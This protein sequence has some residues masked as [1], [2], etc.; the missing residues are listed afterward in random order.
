MEV[1]AAAGPQV[2]APETL[3]EVLKEISR[4]KALL[5]T[6]AKRSALE[7]SCSQQLEGLLQKEAPLLQAARAE[8]PP[9]CGVT[10]LPHEKNSFDLWAERFADRWLG[11]GCTHDPVPGDPA[12][13]GMKK[14]AS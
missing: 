3:E 14:K 11:G 5:R 1:P 12:H 7:L 10:L 6:A 13:R 4:V 8:R 9:Y 2:G